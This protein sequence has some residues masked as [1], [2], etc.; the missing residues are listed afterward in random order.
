MNI[1]YVLMHVSLDEA[2]QLWSKS[3]SVINLVIHWSLSQVFIFAGYLRFRPALNKLIAIV[4]HVSELSAH[5]I[6]QPMSVSEDE[7]I[8]WDGDMFGFFIR[9]K[10][11]HF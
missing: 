3:N 7:V 6:Y 2:I 4:S 11:E 10:A 1:L 5:L 9:G 8:Q